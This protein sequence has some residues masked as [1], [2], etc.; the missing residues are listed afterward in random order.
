MAKTVM[1]G[2]LYTNPGDQGGLG[3]EKVHSAGPKT[4]NVPDPL[5]LNKTKR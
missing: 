2:P 4:V 5:G 1:E 3:G